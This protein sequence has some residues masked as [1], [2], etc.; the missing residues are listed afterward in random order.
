ME[1]NKFNAALSLAA[2]QALGAEVLRASLSGGE[3]RRLDWESCPTPAEEAW[4]LEKFRYKEARPM[5]EFLVRSLIHGGAEK[6]NAV[7]LEESGEY[8]LVE[9]DTLRIPTLLRKRPNDRLMDR[10]SLCAE[11]AVEILRAAVSH[12]E[13]GDT[14]WKSGKS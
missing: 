14:P 4:D 5:G 9:T 11:G 10:V 2:K 13:Q 12:F 7:V 1:S 6:I 3:G 8:L